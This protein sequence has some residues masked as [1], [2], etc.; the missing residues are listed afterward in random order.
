[1]KTIKRKRTE[2]AMGL[3][4]I[5]D[6]LKMICHRI[7]IAVCLCMASVVV[8]GM[9]GAAQSEMVDRIIA[10]VNDDIILQS[11]MEAA[12][13]PIREQLKKGGYSKVQQD[14]ALADQRPFIL[15]QLIT[16]KLTDQ[17]VK[18]FEIRI[19]DEE[20]EATITRIKK[21][22]KLNDEQF[23]QQFGK[24]G[25]SYEEFKSEIKDRL[26]RSKLVNR[27]INSKIAITDEDI[28][29]YYEKNSDSYGGMRKYHLR[30]ILIRDDTNNDTTPGTASPGERIER[31]HERLA[32]GEEF[33]Q[34]ATI[35]S[36][37]TSAASGGDIG[38]FEDRMLAPAI[39]MALMELQE[40]QYSQVIQTDQ[41]FQILYLE[42]LIQIGGKSLED[43]R[44][45]IQD[46]LYAEI[47][48]QRFKDWLK[49]LREQAHV[50]IVE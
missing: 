20:L 45:E 5:I 33:S 13:V 11:D 4:A 21:M 36:E 27:E 15:E 49:K 42:Q 35:Y 12:L 41:G 8:C 10:I 40:G 19:G 32:A 18:R 16:E 2:S 25:L 48:D 50:K 31:V 23:M 30:R 34:L 43:A 14:L 1:M 6:S 24:D 38:I 17:Q 39:R 44:E 9:I 28:K 26:L 37:D 22:N 47:V 46:K 29:A 7:A 3:S